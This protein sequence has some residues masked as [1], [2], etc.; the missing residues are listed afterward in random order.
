MQHHWGWIVGLSFN[1]SSSLSECRC[2]A[3][4][5]AFNTDL[6]QHIKLIKTN[7]SLIFIIV[8]W[9]VKNSCSKCY[10]YVPWGSLLYRLLNFFF[11]NILQRI[12]YCMVMLLMWSPEHGC[13]IILEDTVHL[14]SSSSTG[15]NWFLWAGP[16][17][18]L[19]LV[20]HHGRSSS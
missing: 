17:M 4:I 6:L 13:I 1:L 9:Y 2:S 10:F 7:P 15:P 18:G 8:S 12:V 3:T 20:T 11:E 19:S 14:H 5:W 16:N